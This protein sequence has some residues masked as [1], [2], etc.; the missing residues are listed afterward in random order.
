[1]ARLVASLRQAFD[2]SGVIVVPI[3]AGP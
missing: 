1:V 3:D 2:P